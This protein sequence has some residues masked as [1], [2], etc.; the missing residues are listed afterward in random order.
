MAASEFHP[1]QR[2]ISNTEAELG[3]GIVVEVN[4]R[5]VALDFPAAEEERTYALDNAPLSRVIYPVGEQISTSDGASLEVLERMENNG[6][7]IYMTESEA[8]E[9]RIVPEQEL[10]AS[11]QFSRPQDRLFAGQVDKHRAFKLRIDTL[12]HQHRLN[13]SSS[14]GLIGGRVQLLPHQFYIAE[15]V[16][17]RQAPRVLL[18][19]EVGLGKTIE[20]GLVLHQQLFSGRARRVLVVVPDSLVYQWLV[21]M[22]RR[23]NLQFSVMDELRCTA[24][25]MG[26]DGNPLES[27]Q[28][29]LCS[30]SF[31]TGN[32]QRLQQALAADWDLMVVDEAH[33]LGWSEE[34][35]S[36]AYLTIEQLARHI[37]GVLLLT[38][39]PEQL[40]VDSHFARLRLLDP[41]RYYDLAQFRTEEQGYQAVSALVEQLLADDAAEQLIAAG[42]ELKADLAD[43]LGS[44]A[45]EQQQAQL[46][47]EPEHAIQSLIDQL[48]DR[49]GTGRV[50]FRNTR[51][52]VE[53]F[54]QR[55]LLRH[56]LVAPEGFATLAEE[57]ALTDQLQ[58][59]KLLGDDWLGKDPRVQWLVDWLKPRRT[60]KA[61]LICHNA[62]TANAL[63]EYLRLRAGVRSA[64]FHEGM[65]L[66]NRDRAAAYFADKEEFAQVLV[67]SEIGSE[68][69]NFQFAQHLIM[70]D[71]PLNPDLL[72]QRIGRL[73]RIGQRHDVKIHVPYYQG[74][75]QEV[76]L[77]WYQDGINAFEQTCPAGQLLYR[78]F[79]EQLHDALQGKLDHAALERLIDDSRHEAEAMR[80]ALAAGRNRL[81]EQ[82]SCRRE[83]ADELLAEVEEV[84]NPLALSDYMERVFDHF[85]IESMPHDRNSVVIR[86]SD[87]MLVPH[88]PGLPEDGVT[89]TYQRGEALQR[90]DMQFLSWEH[91]MVS[92]AMEMVLGSEFGNAT[93]CSIKL[94]L[95]PGTLLLEG[96]FRMHCAAPKAAQLARFMPQSSIRLVVDSAGNDLS[97]IITP[98][99]LNKLAERVPRRTAQG[100]VRHAREQIDQM[101]GR[102]EHMAAPQQQRI[103]D[104]AHIG[105]R[106]L[107]DGEIARL[108]ALAGVNPSISTAEVEEL[109]AQREQLFQYLNNGK[110]V[111]DA[112]RL[113]IVTD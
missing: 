86:P 17:K 46:A 85:G 1:G 72:E 15:Q 38:A 97:A 45:I 47:L 102:L 39:T 95:P 100:M 78:Q 32:E 50:L 84:G 36:H 43:Y 90:E 52:A 79:A 112:I 73:D 103:I 8:G 14:F 10:A 34:A 16:G 104:E 68:G 41:D 33:H 67:C 35:P 22:L 30:L 44:E 5:R 61:L 28:L 12:E 89:A 76:L 3:L 18:A 48:I 23:F 26:N 56:P 66:I 94:P 105:C 20:A 6:C 75:A 21:E 19:D 93:V 58:P 54:P 31:L 65:T 24:W 7:Y 107:L 113:V 69:R 63:E 109:Q 82:S 55:Q 42:S 53:G 9:A 71:L 110:L 74:C 64:V 91:P 70:F 62:K 80:Q 83:R 51:D 92:G 106:Q 88:F 59:E 99:H 4:N 60:E 98:A 11:V 111:L 108:Q 101:V 57:A 96:I 2:W 27:A 25:E 29:V 13:G 40:G 87:H 49:H 37:P 81:L 77:D